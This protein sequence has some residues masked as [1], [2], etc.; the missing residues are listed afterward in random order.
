MQ[1]GMLAKGY[2][3]PP[4]IGPSPRRRWAFCHNR[5]TCA[6]THPARLSRLRTLRVATV[7]LTDKL[8]T[9][10]GLPLVL[11]GHNICMEHHSTCL[12]HLMPSQPRPM[13]ASRASHHLVQRLVEWLVLG[14]LRVLCVALHVLAAESPPPDLWTIKAHQVVSCTSVVARF[15]APDSRRIVAFVGSEAEL[16]G[17]LVMSFEFAFGK[18]GRLAGTGC[19]RSY[20]PSCGTGHHNADFTRYEKLPR[21]AC[22][23]VSPLAYHPNCVRAAKQS[24]IG[25]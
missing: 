23:G 10:D 1:D 14:K 4:T 9:G 7:L 16:A 18:S 25:Q 2:A 5:G 19:A 3:C 15:D 21:D 17:L 12:L 22:A 13:C 24:T 11:Y 6:G 8:E 20:L